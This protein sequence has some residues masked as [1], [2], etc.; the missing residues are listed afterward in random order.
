MNNLLQEIAAEKENIERTLR[1]L[2]DTLQRPSR[3][4]VELAAIATC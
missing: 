3:D 4:F 1:A 2:D